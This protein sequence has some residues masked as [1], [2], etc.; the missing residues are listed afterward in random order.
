L[1]FIITP[2]QK[3]DASQAE[4]LI[5]RFEAEAILADKGYDSDVIREAARSK[6]MIPHIPPR[7]NRLEKI[8]YD[9]HL[10]KERH[11]V[12]CLF[13]FLKHYRR[14]FARFDK[15]KKCFVAFLHFISAMQWL[16]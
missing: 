11:K 7:S 6:G 13:G 5:S 12:E 2:G 14:L 3:H 1:D 16:K 4:D 9:E 10:Y 15:T 8:N